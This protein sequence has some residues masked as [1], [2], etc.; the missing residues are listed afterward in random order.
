MLPW[1]ELKAIELLYTLSCFKEFTCN[2]VF[3]VLNSSYL[4]AAIHCPYS[5]FPTSLLF[6]QELY[7]IVCFALVNATVYLAAQ[8]LVSH[9]V[10]RFF[11]L[12][13]LRGNVH[14]SVVS[15]F[16]THLYLFCYYCYN[17]QA[18]ILFT[19]LV[20]PAKTCR[21]FILPACILSIYSSIYSWSWLFATIHHVRQHNYFIKPQMCVS[22]YC[23]WYEFN[24]MPK[25][26]YNLSSYLSLFA[27]LI[28]EAN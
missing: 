5:L 3:K 18:L 12:N 11:I 14:Q 28:E 27:S 24:T 6:I 10:K 4:T 13:S 16:S 1:L 20:F 23:R 9:V 22:F 26:V 21:S 7:T 2:R 8:H 19:Y 15:A 17:F 25:S